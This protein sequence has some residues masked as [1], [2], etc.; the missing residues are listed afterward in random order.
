MTRLI[1]ADALKEAFD[2]R[3]DKSWDGA[4]IFDQIKE[5]IDNAPEVELANHLRDRIKVIDHEITIPQSYEAKCFLDGK[6]KAF[7]YVLDLL[8]GGAEHE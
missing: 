6:R 7:Q 5:L 4:L 1:D 8:K 3:C 2:W